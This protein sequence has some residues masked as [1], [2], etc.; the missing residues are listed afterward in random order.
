MKILLPAILNPLSRRKDK[1]VKL[2]FESREMSAE[3]TMTLLAL[4]GSEGYL[5]FSPNET[6]IEIP[7]G[8]IE[9]GSKTAG[10]RMR[11]VIFILYKQEVANGKY[12]G[13]FDNF[14]NERMEKLIQLLKDKIND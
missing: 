13:L 3:E 12:V 7:T 4:E 14:Y 11:A 10:Q 2:S 6:E 9:V 1:S 8:N 5:C